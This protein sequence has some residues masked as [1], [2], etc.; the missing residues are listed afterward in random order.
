MS[1]QVRALGLSLILMF[2]CCAS[3]R[4]Q[5]I[6]VIAQPRDANEPFEAA[7]STL[8]ARAIVAEIETRGYAAI[9][10]DAEGRTDSCTL[11][12]EPTGNAHLTLYAWVQQVEL[13]RHAPDGDPRVFGG[14]VLLDA[15][16][17]RLAGSLGVS[18]LV[19]VGG[20]AHTAA[21]VFEGPTAQVEDPQAVLGPV[22]W[23]WQEERPVFWLLPPG[24]EEDPLAV[25]VRLE[26]VEPHLGLA[27][28]LPVE[29]SPAAPAVVE[30]AEA[31]TDG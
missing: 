1:M 25:G 15:D 7:F 30:A 19:T 16:G 13:T 24:A 10:D 4:P 14:L 21:E 11:I 18:Q 6:E 12:D 28:V 23:W 9:L 31:S 17:Q 3:N 27:T 8:M 5:A 29:P 20:L 26:M 2:A 22:D